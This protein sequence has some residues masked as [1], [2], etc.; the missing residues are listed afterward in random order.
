MGMRKH[1]IG[2]Q[3]YSTIAYALSLTIS[4]ALFCAQDSSAS[5]DPLDYGASQVG[6]GDTALTLPEVD[7]ICETLQNAAN[8]KFVDKDGK[9]ISFRK[10]GC[11]VSDYRN[12]KE[13]C[14]TTLS[15]VL[16]TAGV[17]DSSTP[18]EREEQISKAC[19][20]ARNSDSRIGTYCALHDI[21]KS[22]SQTLQYCEAHKSAQK[23][24]K[25]SEVLLY[26]NLG[27]AA[28]CWKEYLAHQAQIGAGGAAGKVASAFG[29]MKGVC[30]STAA[31]SVLAEVAQMTGILGPS[32]SVGK[33]RVNSNNN[34]VNTN[35]TIHVFELIAKSTLSARALQLS[36]CYNKSVAQSASKVLPFLKCDQV[37]SQKHIAKTKMQADSCPIPSGKVTSIE[38][39]EITHHLC[40]SKSCKDYRKGNES[41]CKEAK[42]YVTKAEAKSDDA[43][44]QAEIA[45]QTAIVFSS[46]ALIRARSVAGAALTKKKTSEILQSIF[47]VNSSSPTFGNS[48]LG[49]QQMNLLAMTSN[50]GFTTSPD[51]RG[52]NV[53]ASTAKKGEVESFLLPPGSQLGALGER[54]AQS[55]PKSVLDSATSGGGAGVG[56][57]IASMASAMGAQDPR[58]EI[59]RTIASAFANLPQETGGYGGGGGSGLAKSSSSG[60]GSDLNLKALFGGAE[61]GGGEQL[62]PGREDIAFRSIASEDDIWHSKN[63]KG[64]NLFQIVSDKYDNVQRKHSLGY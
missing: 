22:G 8:G 31:L 30:S 16:A 15:S 2:N 26:S 51:N 1:T 19:S 27:V 9:E 14:S 35:T 43:I 59:K 11:S 13:G 52:M 12:N 10:S 41:L 47:S 46:M 36:L 49:N 4:S 42:E 57:A 48:G 34:A 25:S 6:K 29:Q 23:A 54:V 33:Y 63:P 50:L 61:G 17:K 55:T 20:S 7:R 39:A 60:S 3:P 21:S 18:E 53:A 32:R 44:Q 62:S 24:A 56:N 28:L 64:H 45:R 40:T 58:G 37:G 38:E 5:S